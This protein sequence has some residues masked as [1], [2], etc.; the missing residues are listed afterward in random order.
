MFPALRERLL[1]RL[2]LLVE[3]GTLGEYGIGEDGYPLAL[4]PECERPGPVPARTRGECLPPAAP[5][6]RRGSSRPRA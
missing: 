3:L 2:D 1:D 6:P 5:R 4:E